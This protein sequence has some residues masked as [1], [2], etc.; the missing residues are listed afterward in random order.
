VINNEERIYERKEEE[1]G[2]VQ[3]STSH[4]EEGK[5]KGREEE[6]KEE[7]KGR[8]SGRGRQRGTRIRRGSGRRTVCNQ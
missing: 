3:E 7:G 8:G 4:W 5:E 1:M 2:R 6:V